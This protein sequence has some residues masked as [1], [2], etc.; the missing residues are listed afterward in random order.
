MRILGVDYGKKRLGL[1]ISDPLCITAQGLPT[2][3]RRDIAHDMEALAGIIQEW[4]IDEIVVGLP[5]RMDNTLGEAAQEALAFAEELRGRFPLT[6][7]L[8]DERLSTVRAHRAMKE[9]GLSRKKRTERADMVSAQ[10]ILQDYLDQKSRRSR[11]GKD[12]N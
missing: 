3:E 8:M 4:G 9:G 10:L 6:V 12:N 11:E 5:K 1:A 2:L 7:H